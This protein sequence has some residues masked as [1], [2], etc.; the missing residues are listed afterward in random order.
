[1]RMNVY[2]LFAL[3]ISV[4]SSCNKETPPSAFSYYFVASI[5]NAPVKF[6]ADVRTFGPFECFPVSYDEGFTPNFTHYE[7]TTFKESVVVPSEQITIAIVKKFDH[8]PQLP[9]R[10]L[11]WKLG[12]MK[13]YVAGS[14]A[15]D[16]VSITYADNSGKLWGS[17]YGP[18]DGNSFAITQIWVE[19]V[20]TQFK[21][22]FNCMLYDGNG[23]SIK[24]ENGQIRGRL[25]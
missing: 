23:N 14:T 21:A 20:Y 11:M 9:E 24:L 2:I 12:F 1:M 25:F 22:R 4:F 16:A 8:L 18:Q 7:G 17:Q 3:I 19:D 13:Y 15:N 10:K 5:N 6:E